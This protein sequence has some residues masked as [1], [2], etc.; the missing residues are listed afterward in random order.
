M[1][2]LNVISAMGFDT[3]EIAAT[4]EGAVLKRLSPY[5]AKANQ[6]AVKPDKDTSDVIGQQCT[7]QHDWAASWLVTTRLDTTRVHTRR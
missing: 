3:D 1:A 2:I 5:R 4:R 6:A 7:P